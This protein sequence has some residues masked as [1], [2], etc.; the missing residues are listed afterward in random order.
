MST[1]HHVILIHPEASSKPAWGAPCNGCGVC[2]LLEPCPLG[3]VLSRKRQ[4]AC[5]ALRWL[6]DEHQYRCGALMAPA[7]VLQQ[8]LPRPLTALVPSLAWILARLAR[9]WI[10]AGQGCDSTVQAHD[11]SP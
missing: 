10:A 4:G 11:D 9:R 3:V 1:S 6:P 7:Q 5:A 8:A 2:C